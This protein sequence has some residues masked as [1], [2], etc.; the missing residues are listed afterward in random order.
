MKERLAIVLAGL[1]LSLAQC[2]G[3]V[4]PAVAPV[5]ATPPVAG[6]VKAFGDAKV[7]DRQA[8]PILGGI[9][10]V[11]GASPKAEY[12]G[13]TYYFCCPD[14]VEKFKADPQKYVPKGA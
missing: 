6:D 4:A 12:N 8:C 14:C 5:P 13:K 10:T 9:F 11:T 1:S 3:G 2:G 7:G